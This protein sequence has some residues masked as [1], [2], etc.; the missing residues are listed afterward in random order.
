MKT[1]EKGHTMDRDNLRKK[2]S[3]FLLTMILACNFGVYSCWA[4]TYYVS[5]TSGNDFNDGTSPE[6]PW[7]RI[8]SVV[9]RMM[10]STIKA[11]DSVL[12]KRGDTWTA[13]QLSI[14]ASGTSDSVRITFG[15]YGSG[16]LPKIDG[17]FSNEWHGIISIENG[18]NWI[19]IE[20]LELYNAQNDIIGIC[21]DSPC[22]VHGITIRNCVLHD[23]AKDF[24]GI[25][26]HNKGTQGNTKNIL[27]EGNTIYNIGHNG[28][29]LNYGVTNA[30]IRD[31]T[32]HDC[33]HHGIDAWW[34]VGKSKNANFTITGNTIY[35]VN[36]G[37]FLPAT[38]N[39]LIEDNDI[40][41]GVPTDAPAVVGIFLDY[42]G[43]GSES[44]GCTIRRNR[45]WNFST[46]NSNTKALWISNATNTTCVHNTIYKNYGIL[47]NDLNTNL[48]YK[49]NLAYANTI[50]TNFGSNPLFVNPTGT[51][52][53]FHLQADS[54]AI[55]IGEDIG[56]P[57]W[58]K[59]P[60][61][62]AYEYIKKP[63]PPTA[64]RI[65]SNN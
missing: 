50:G 7:K 12:F 56:L 60:D 4:A 10:D 11:G 31:N 48:I 52:P 40:H 53:D 20:N 27:I 24:M 25:Q 29:R 65:I 63:R 41:D 38:D 13:E 54:P 14:T 21:E 18:V 9:Q 8:A 43:P 45:I 32:I 58:G 49:N 2:I 62:G 15:A 55:D 16:N 17:N 23:N 30:T 37:I 36:G 39:A 3:L 6:A 22:S 44:N 1:F 57:Y 47:E 26:V 61:L 46:V 42:L 5:S 19:T 33:D 28:M 51:P 64:L 35:N 59:A 34:E